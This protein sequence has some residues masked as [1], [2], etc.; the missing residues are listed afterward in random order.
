MIK[1]E[2]WRYDPNIQQSLDSPLG[3]TIAPDVTETEGLDHS[4]SIVPGGLLVTS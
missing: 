4:H 3:A 1:S 2:R